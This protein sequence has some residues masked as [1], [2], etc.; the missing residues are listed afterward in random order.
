MGLDRFRNIIL[1]AQEDHNPDSPKYKIGGPKIHFDLIGYD[2]LFWSQDKLDEFKEELEKRIKRR[3]ATL[4]TSSQPWDYEWIKNHREIAMAG[5]ARSNLSG[6]MEVSLT[7]RD[8]KLNMKADELLRAAEK[9]QIN[10]FGWPLGAMNGTNPEFRP[11]PTSEGIFIELDSKGRETYDYWAL[12]K[13]G[14]FYLLKSLFEDMREPGHIFFNTRIVRITETLLYT[15]RLYSEL[16]IPLESF[17]LIKIRHG[18][19]KER[20]LTASGDRRL[21]FFNDRKSAENEV[22]TEAE[23]TLERIEPDIIELVEKFTA[24]LFEI[25]DYFE[26]EKKV[27]EEI[28]DQFVAGKVT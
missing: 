18:G 5:L 16:K 12:R 17:V 9:A 13:D 21:T 3:M 20:V 19:L 25:F 24:P 6:L 4:P 8:L 28:V 27:L 22:E 11:K 2:I 23:T 10:T 1:T 26:L 14:T 7:L 15:V